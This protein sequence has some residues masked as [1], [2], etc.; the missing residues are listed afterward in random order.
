[1]YHSEEKGNNKHALSGKRVLT[2]AEFLE[3]L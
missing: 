2:N 1:M 3:E